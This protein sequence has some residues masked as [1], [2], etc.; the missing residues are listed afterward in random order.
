MGWTSHIRTLCRVFHS[1]TQAGGDG[2]RREGDPAFPAADQPGR[3]PTGPEMRAPELEF[4]LKL[5]R[6]G[7]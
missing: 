7:A 5:K 4:E 2:P 1:H 6:E 3:T